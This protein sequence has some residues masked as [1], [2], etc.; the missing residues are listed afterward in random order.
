MNI[1]NTWYGRDK[2]SRNQWDSKRETERKC[3]DC[4]ARINNRCDS[5][6]EPLYLCNNC[7]RELDERMFRNFDSDDSSRVC[8]HCLV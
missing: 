2:F 6:S 5:D 3:I 7:E 1:C 8:E 4:V